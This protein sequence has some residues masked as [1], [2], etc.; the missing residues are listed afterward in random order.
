MEMVCRF[1]VAEFDF[2]CTFIG[3]VTGFPPPPPPPLLEVEPPQDSM[4]PATVTISRIKA[5]ARPADA[6]RDPAPRA[7]T[8]TAKSTSK[9]APQSVMAH[10]AGAFHGC[11]PESPPG[12]RFTADVEGFADT[13]TLNDAETA[14]LAGTLT[15]AGLKL[16]LATG[17]A[18]LHAKVTFPEKEFVPLSDTVKVPVPPALIVADAGVIE[19]VNPPTVNCVDCVCVNPPPVP[20][21]PTEYAPAGIVAGRVTVRLEGVPEAEAVTVAG[22]NAHCAPAGGFAQASVTL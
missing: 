14:P 21:T 2:A 4:P 8:K 3:K 22:L 13:L 17:G 1:I 11:Q 16:Q 12:A 5:T 19:V 15:V 10:A 6:K 20:V 18:P 9:P 7:E